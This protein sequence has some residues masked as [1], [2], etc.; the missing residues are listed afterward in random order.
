[1]DV[2]PSDLTQMD[3]NISV[4]IAKKLAITC[5][6]K[7]MNTD[8]FVHLFSLILFSAFNNMT[9]LDVLTAGDA[10]QCTGHHGTLISHGHW[11]PNPG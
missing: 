5:S 11:W 4:C 8:N 7:N 10:V 3:V 1:M 9:N 2:I 6:M